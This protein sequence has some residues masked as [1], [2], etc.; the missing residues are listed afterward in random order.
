MTMVEFMGSTDAFS[1]GM[2]SD[3]ALRSTVVTI[4]ALDRSPDWD[5][6][7]DR[8]RH[9][10]RRLPMFR[11]R[12]V[13]SPP[14][15]PPRWELDPDF[16]LYWH[17]RRVNAP[18]PGSF[19]AVLECARQAEMADFDRARPLWE[20]ILVEGLEGGKAALVCKVHH[21]LT[22]GVGGV[23]IAMILFDPRRPAPEL[24][25]APELP[26]PPVLDGYRKAARYDLALATTAA[27]TV[28][29]SGPKALL[30]AVRNPV[31][32]VRT[33]AETA[34]SVYRTVR[35]ISRPGSR[36]MGERRLIRRLGVHE[37][38]LAAL[39]EAG[40]ACGGTL[41][42]AFLAGVTG[43]LRIYH[44]KHGAEVHDLHVTMPVSLRTEAD[45]MGGNRI[46][47]MRF[48]LAVD[49]AD[50]AE[51]LSRIHRRAKELRSERSLPWTDVIAAGLNLMPRWYLAS[52]LR[53]V[54]LVA[55]DVPGIPVPVELCGAKVEMQYPFGPT[56][57]AAV[58]ITLMS[59]VDTCAIGINVDTGAVPDFEVFRDCIVAG[60]D[61]VLGL[62][63]G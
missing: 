36:L 11:E 54:D 1:W 6:L 22:D 60:F 35:P 20:S 46:T 32:A 9:L 45:P 44:D 7:V 24:E 12:I 48:D 43:G 17:L 63:A 5:E 51:R 42:D 26:R 4:F 21:A 52:V 16:D 27:H 62:T 30:G 59:Y 13:P 38:P 29:R 39:K 37:V 10:V 55:S 50:P 14:P 41:N 23:Q 34:A 49:V 18:S 3:P 31:T 33:T 19:D 53:H 15:A 47:L 28:V 8:H 58:N 25:P 57:G 61:E 40:R 2:E 56:I